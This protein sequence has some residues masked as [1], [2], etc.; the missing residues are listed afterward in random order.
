[1]ENKILL[2][3]YQEIECLLY[4]SSPLTSAQADEFNNPKNLSKD[5][6]WENYPKAKIIC[7]LNDNLVSS[8][9]EDITTD[10][11]TGY[12]ISKKTTG[13]NFFTKVANI[14][15]QE[16]ENSELPIEEGYYKLIDYNVKNNNQ[17]QY[18]V[19]PLTEDYAQAQLT[20]TIIAK[21]D[22]FTL[23]PIQQITGTRYAIVRDENNE[24]IIWSFQ[25]NCS[26][27]DISLNRDI[28][29]FNT[30]TSKPKVSIG[31]THYH[32]GQLSCL[33]G[34]M[35]YNDTYYESGYMLDKWN[36]TIQNNHLFLFKNAKGDAMIVALEDG[37][38]RKYM[39]EAMNYY[40]NALDDGEV[41]TTRPTTITFS[42]IEVLDAKD[43]QIYR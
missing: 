42:Y 43:I 2:Y 27:G 3:G 17:Y 32:K 8:I 20:E 30:F 29:T 35:L 26:E 9:I 13:E 10:N 22:I 4:S 16:L 23:T 19:I 41:I 21:W 36:Q 1:M 25:M 31:E 6:E 33:L 14:S 28:T 12:E 7:N 5:L 39:N 40:I 34:N 37:I 24:P 38:Q 18:Q 11:I 15:T